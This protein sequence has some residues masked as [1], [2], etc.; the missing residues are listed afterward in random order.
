MLIVCAETGA[1]LAL[2]E[3]DSDESQDAPSSRY[4]PQAGRSGEQTGSEN[5]EERA[6][7]ARMANA[8]VN[9]AAGY[10]AAAG[11]LS[12]ANQSC[13]AEIAF[14]TPEYPSLENE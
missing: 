3:R 2:F 6:D 5:R 12:F 8:A 10:F 14:N 11:K 13:T 1:E 7:V 9:S 4:N